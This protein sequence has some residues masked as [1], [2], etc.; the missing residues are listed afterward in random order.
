MKQLDTY[1]LLNVLFDKKKK[2]MVF[3]SKVKLLFVSNTEK[4]G[5]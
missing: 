4:E 2:E 1:T 5:P 3:F